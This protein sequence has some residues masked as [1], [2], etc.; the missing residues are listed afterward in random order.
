MSPHPRTFVFTGPTLDADAVRRI[1]P[2]AIVLPPIAATDLWPLELT[3]AD[4][5][6]V[7]DGFFRE[8]RSIRHK[9]LVEA[10]DRGVLVAGAS[11]MGALRAAELDDFGMIGVGRIYGWYADGIIEGDDEV[12]V[13]HGPAEDGYSPRTLALVNVRATLDIAVDAGAIDRALAGQVAELI[14]TMPFTQRDE[15]SIHVR[16]RDACGQQASTQVASALAAFEYDLKRA[17]AVTLLESIRDGQLPGEQVQHPSPHVQQTD[18]NRLSLV[19]QWRVS[20]RAEKHEGHRISSGFVVSCARILS[21][22]YP[23]FHESVAVDAI[24]DDARRELDDV[25]VQRSDH[26]DDVII[27]RLL[28]HRGLLGDDPNAVEVLTD[29]WLSADERSALNESARLRRA[30]RRMHTATWRS[31]Q[32]VERLMAT[33][34]FERWRQVALRVARLNRSLLERKPDFAFDAI[35]SAKLREWCT[36]RWFA[37]LDHVDDEVWWQ[38][39][40][41]RGYIEERR[42]GTARLVYPFALLRSSRYDDLDWV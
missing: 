36:A 18:V 2:Q 30:V 25:P 19:A 28:V 23:R 38:A 7:I 17:D 1:L 35:P 6:A 11:S 9:E 42:L 15:D 5:L 41:D 16:V 34:R 3:S 37:G 4:T 33:G 40:A 32:A 29:P 26:D 22:D 24:V 12:A 8:R 31:E 21:L 13:M 27:R 39:L 20:E 10:L 14:R